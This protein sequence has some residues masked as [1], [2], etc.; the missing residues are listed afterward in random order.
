MNELIIPDPFSPTRE[1]LFVSAGNNGRSKDNKRN[2][3]SQMPQQ[4]L[5]HSLGENICIWP[6]KLSCSVV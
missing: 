6:S 2:V 5:S 3:F 4:H 1:R